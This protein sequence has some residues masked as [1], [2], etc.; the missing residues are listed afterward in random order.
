MTSNLSVCYELIKMGIVYLSSFVVNGYNIFLITGVTFLASLL[1][2]EMMKR[3]AVFLKVL[4]YPNDKR[5]I[6]TKPMPLLGG[7]GIF[8]A[9]LLGYM[10]FAP[11]NNLMLSILI[12]AFLIMLLGLFDD[13]TQNIALTFRSCKIR[14]DISDTR[15]GQR[16][17]TVKMIY[18][19]TVGRDLV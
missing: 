2:V 3:V 5:K 15:I 14:A 6:H 10:L 19:G 1:F 11:K 12:S 16:L 8:L 9:F 17:N 13:M 7:I 18:A 4:D